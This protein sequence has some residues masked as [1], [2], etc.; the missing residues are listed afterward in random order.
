MHGLC[1]PAACTAWAILAVPPAG[2]EALRE[3]ARR[4]ADDAPEMAVQLA[5]VVEANPLRHIRHQRSLSQQLHRLRH[6]Y[7][8]EVSVRRQPHLGAEG[9]QQVELVELH[10]RSQLVE[11]DLLGP[12]VLQEGT[13]L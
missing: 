6:S 10:V 12:G 3:A 2:A 11:G 1:R 7:L 9:A 13:R 4:Q 5:L 8:R